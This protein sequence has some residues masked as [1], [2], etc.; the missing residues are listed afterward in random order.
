MSTRTD[1]HRPSVIVP[2]DYRFVALGYQGPFMWDLHY[3]GRRILEAHMKRTGGNWSQHE[4]GGNCHI[5]GA[6]CLYTAIFHHVPSNVYIRTGMDCAEKMECDIGDGERFRVMIHNALEAQAG[7]RKAQAFLAS[8]DLVRAWDIAQADIAID[9]PRLSWERRTLGDIVG[10][11]V[12][13][14]SISDKQV[15]FVRNLV[16]KIDAPAD[17]KPVGP[18]SQFLGTIDQRMTFTARIM[19]KTC[20]EGGYGMTYVCGLKDASGNVIIVKG[21]NPLGYG[22]PKI[23][24]KGDTVTFKATIKK[25]NVREGV[26]QTIVNRPKME[27]V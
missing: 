16:A 18:V 5:C 20:F 19:F 8:V 22:S 13:F 23:V 27:A 3:E 21:S 4:H 1:T 14:G 7:K 26:N 2:A 10:K 6:H 15:A 11:L 25:H 9:A 17:T 12:R 24:D